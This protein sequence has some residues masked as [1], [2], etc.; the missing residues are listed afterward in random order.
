M[1]SVHH[2]IKWEIN[3]M[4]IRKVYKNIYFLNNHKSKQNLKRDRKCFDLNNKNTV[5]T[6]NC[7]MHL[8]Q[9]EENWVLK[10]LYYKNLNYWA[11]HISQEVRN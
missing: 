8:K 6:R 5:L 10:L 9:V 2:I 7:G 3:K 1:F 11:D 4:V